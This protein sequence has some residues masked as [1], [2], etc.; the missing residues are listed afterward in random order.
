LQT[1]NDAYHIISSMPKPNMTLTTHQLNTRHHTMTRFD[2]L[3]RSEIWPI[4]C[5]NN[6]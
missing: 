2:Y 1:E 3:S 6:M 4:N 5:K